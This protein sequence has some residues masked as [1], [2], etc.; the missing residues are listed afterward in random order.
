MYICTPQVCLVSLEAKD[1]IRLTRTRVTNC[2]AILWVLKTK[3]KPYARVA[4]ILLS[5]ISWYG[6]KHH[7]TCTRETGRW[8]LRGIPGHPR[9]LHRNPVSKQRKKKKKQQNTSH[10]LCGKKASET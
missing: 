5:K 10:L 4:R 1:D 2:W 9:L 8:P 6:G 7:N 3:P